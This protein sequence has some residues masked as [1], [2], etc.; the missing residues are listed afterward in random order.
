[1]AQRVNAK[2]SAAALRK[3]RTSYHGAG[4]FSFKYLHTSHL[5]ENTN[6]RVIQEYGHLVYILI[7]YVKLS[8]SNF[9]K[10][11]NLIKYFSKVNN[12]CRSIFNTNEMKGNVKQIKL[13]PELYMTDK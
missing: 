5:C 3:R 4:M 6:I 2:T 12:Y 13:L 11:L 9:S 7:C 10:E 1:M 8:N